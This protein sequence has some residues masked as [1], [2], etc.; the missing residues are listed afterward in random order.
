MTLGVDGILSRTVTIAALTH[1]EASSYRLIRIPFDSN[2]R[3]HYYTVEYRVADSWDAG[4]PNSTLMIN[5]VKNNNSYYQTTL[6]RELGQ[7]AGTGDG[8]PVQSLNAN[9]VDDQLTEYFRQHGDGAGQYAIRIALRA[10][11]C[12]ARGVFDRPRLRGAGD[13]HPGGGG[14]RGRRIAQAAGRWPVWPRHLQAGVCV[15]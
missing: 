14:Q 13:A 2:D 6:I 15:A 9:G 8:P 1:P 5:E 4:I 3:F 12:V 10:G 11:L 7:Y